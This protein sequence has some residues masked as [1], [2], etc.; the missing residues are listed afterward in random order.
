MA[1][2]RFQ[3]LT[4]LGLLVLLSVGCGSQPENGLN[5]KSTY[6]SSEV[7]SVPQRLSS[8]GE[9][10]LR[11]FLNTAEMS[12]LHWPNFT[13]YQKDVK[14]F[15]AAFSGTLPWID[16]GKPTAQARAIIRSFKNAADKGLRPED[17]DAP[18]WDERLSQFDQS[19]A[20][21]ES[22]LV[23]FD[24]ALTVST[25]R[26]ISD[27]HVGRVNP[28]LFHF[29]LDIDHQQ[30]DL[31]DF[32]RQKLV[33]ATDIDAVLRTVEPPF[34]IYSRTQDALKKYM[35][36]ARL[37]DGELLP[38]TPRTIK[39]GDSYAGVLRL[40]KLLTLLGDFLGEHDAVATEGNYQ[41]AVVDA[42]KHFQ[43]R[44]GLEPSGVLDAATLKTLNTPLSRRI[45][46]L[47]LAMERMRWLPHQF[48]RPPI[49]VNIPEFRLYAIN[50]EYLSVF[51]MNVVVGKAYGHQT[52]VFAN[53]I[54]S[55]IFRPYWNVPQS[56]VNVELIPHLE[57]DPSYLSAHSYEIVD[58]NERVVSEEPV[59]K[60]VEAELHA[61]DLR[62]RQTPG[63]QNALGLVKFEFP[64]QYD[65]Y[66]HGTPAE[67]L[68]SRTRRDFS[69]GCIRV[70]D[71]VKL[72]TWVLRDMPGWT[73]DSVR[74]AMNGEETIQAKLME[75]IPVLILYSTAVILEGG[76]VHFFDDI[77]GLDADLERA[78]AQNVRHVTGAEV[79]RKD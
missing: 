71:P 63:P 12:D 54:K 66:M 79:P 4:F 7:P 49:V 8:D 56:I 39:P 65:V 13:N 11:N 48:A 24:L 62:V 20:A 38:V 41:G 44:H 23:K 53:E 34:P 78:L 52:P 55:V 45:A 70:E 46:Q 58:K 61:G 36:F 57:K 51:T 28:R 18:Q 60:D 10:S 68:F 73:E 3:K 17:Y 35:K 26:Y 59:S 29:G 9:A 6:A 72:A 16:E 74:A 15:Y 64:N 30:L 47:Q 27:L 31:S 77:Y 19:M 50:N 5:A 1:C 67:E 32:L 75:P 21:P 22:D 40:T 37:D 43:R 69:H 14:E 42:V 33:G 2:R 25:M 76:D